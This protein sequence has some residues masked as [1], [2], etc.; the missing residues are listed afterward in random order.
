MSE[1]SEAQKAYMDALFGKISTIFNEKILELNENLKFQVAEIKQDFNKVINTYEEKINK[2]ELQNQQLQTSIT[3][4]QRRIKKNNIV[5]FG[6]K[7]LEENL[8]VTILELFKNT[9]E[10]DISEKDINDIYKIGKNE[11]NP[12]VIEFIS[13]QTKLL[14]LRNAKKLKGKN[15]SISSDLCFEDRENNKIL[16]VHM[17]EAKKKGLQAYIRGNKLIVGKD[18]YTAK[19]LSITHLST[20]DSEHQ[21][22][23]KE[24]PGR[25][26]SAPSTPNP[27]LRDKRLLKELGLNETEEQQDQEHKKS[28]TNIKTNKNKISV[29][30]RSNSTVSNN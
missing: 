13:F 30:T 21:Q 14:V 7:N 28:K 24:T 16:A 15:I 26:G 23:N 25:S 17:K 20:T 4:L 11:N 5:I 12:V 27:S 3:K 29:K 9:L 1:F 18:V 22:D 2:L 8:W 6:T 10:I 19:Q